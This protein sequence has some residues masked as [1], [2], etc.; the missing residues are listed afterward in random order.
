MVIKLKTVTIQ[1]QQ[2]QLMMGGK[3]WRLALFGYAISA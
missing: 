1:A 2:Q 3:I